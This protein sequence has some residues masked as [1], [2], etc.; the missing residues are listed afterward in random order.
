MYKKL[1][2]AAIPFRD[3]IG[4]PFEG[5]Y[6]KEICGTISVETND[7]KKTPSVPFVSFFS[8]LCVAAELIKYHSKS[9][10]E[11]PMM[12]RLDFLQMNLF[13]P[14]CLLRARRVKNPRCTLGCSDKPLQKHFSKKW[15]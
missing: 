14:N 1:Q 5:V 15:S 7:G 6:K 8:G 2:D 13:T 12:N 4:K 9:F 3:M 11:L 10:E